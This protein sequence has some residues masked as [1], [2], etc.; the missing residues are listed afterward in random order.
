[1]FFFIPNILEFLSW[2]NIA[3]AQIFFLS[4]IKVIMSFSLA[5]FFP[6]HVINCSHPIANVKLTLH[7]E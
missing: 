6:V 3:L 4:L 2:I 1:M 5:P 7:M